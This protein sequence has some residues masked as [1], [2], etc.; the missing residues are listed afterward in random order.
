VRLP[1]TVCDRA[2]YVNADATGKVANE[3]NKAA[4]AEISALWNIVKEIASNE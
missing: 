3:I 2:D 4:A 1:L